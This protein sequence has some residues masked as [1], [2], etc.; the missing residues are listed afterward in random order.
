MLAKNYR[1]I[2]EAILSKREAIRERGNQLSPVTL[3]MEDYYYP[4]YNS[5]KL[6]EL[7]EAMKAE[8]IQELEKEREKTK[9]TE[10][11][12]AKMIAEEWLK[13]MGQ[14]LLDHPIKVMIESGYKETLIY[15]PDGTG[16]LAFD[17]GKIIK[18]M[19]KKEQGLRVDK[20]QVGQVEYVIQKLMG[21]SLVFTFN[22]G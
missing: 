20:I 2:Y 1:Y 3:C 16:V 19:A 10:G 11:E 4:L 5:E 14:I 8:L 15:K 6:H 9:H 12:W 21:E 13:G 17:L 7:I 22:L 18:V